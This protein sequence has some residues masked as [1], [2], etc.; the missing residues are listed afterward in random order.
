MA[1]RRAVCLL[2]GCAAGT[3]LIVGCVSGIDGG[4]GEPNI[5]DEIVCDDSN[6][7]TED[8]CDPNDVRVCVFTDAPA[9]TPCNG[10]GIC[11]GAGECVACNRDEQCPD[12]P[13][14]CTAPI[15]GVNGC[16]VVPDA[17][18]ASCA[19]GIC[20]DGRCV[21]DG[22]LLPCTEQGIRNAVAAG[23]GPY[24][25]DC[26]GPT[27][28]VTKAE[29]N[30]D[31]DVVLDGGGNVIL[32]GND[33]HRLFSVGDQVVA[34]LDG[35]VLTGGRATRI[36]DNEGCGGL[37][38]VGILTLVNSVVSNNTAPSGGGGG[39]C[40][41]GIMTLIDSAVVDNSAK[42]CAGIFS[43]IWLTLIGS[44]VS[45]NT[46]TA[47]GGGICNSGTLE[48]ASST[49]SENAAAQAGG[50]E[51]SGIL[52]SFNSTISGNTSEGGAAGLFNFG[53]TTV[54]SSTISGNQVA[55][56]P[57]D[58]RNAGTLT[59]SNTLLDGACTTDTEPVTSEGYNIE[60][61]GNT[62]LFGHPTDR[63]NVA[64]SEV[65][66]GELADNGG[67]TMTHA[68]LPGSVAIDAIPEDACNSSED[69]RGEPRPEAPGSMCDVGAFELQ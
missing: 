43:N 6:D 27:T 17:D 30:I 1:L 18:G 26:D 14:E 10:G 45:G 32:D 7:C 62:C 9:D 25:F 47:G 54:R 60:S 35:F 66:L 68:L 65:D 2:V 38:N 57:A 22:L 23:G 53:T 50:I 40:N 4:E 61:A 28:I 39:L 67:L 64:G 52:F 69:Q 20:E 5:C 36:I 12:G 19:G 16:A 31:R 24:T 56:V 42:S 11:D 8:V 51:S 59:I 13:G 63:V 58:I 46:A 41:V 3:P 55:A 33:E 21:L 15:C 37:S 49:V 48:L 29:I 34:E 44:T